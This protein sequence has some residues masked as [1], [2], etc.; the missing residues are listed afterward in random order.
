MRNGERWLVGDDVTDVV[1]ASG[2][3]AFDALD[4]M[5]RG[6]F[7]AGFVAYD[8]GRTIERV[9]SRAPDDLGLPDLAFARFGRVREMDVL[10]PQPGEEDVQ[11]GAGRSSLSRAEH[12]AR[13][14][15]IHTLLR[16]GDCYQVN[17][18]RRLEFD[19]APEPRALFGALSP[20]IPRRTPRCAPLATRSR[21]S[22]WRR[23]HPSC[24]SG[25]RAGRWRPVRSRAPRPSG[26][27]SRRAART[28]PRTS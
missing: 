14:E 13:V 18:T 23:H 24:S 17:L 6:G 28:T 9:A 1:V 2:A 26:A 25:S 8:L 21:A 16:D 27:R 19:A 20:R 5:A 10:P 4:A 11:L 12:A 7:W 15:A 22:P 3:D